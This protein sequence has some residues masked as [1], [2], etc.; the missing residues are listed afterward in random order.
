MAF[1]E[2]TKVQRD[3]P[4]LLDIPGTEL[5]GLTLKAPL[6]SYET[7]YTLPMSSLTI[8]NATGI[9][10]GVPSDVPVDMRALWELK[11]YPTLREKYNITEEMIDI[12]PISIIEIPGIGSSSAAKMV[13]KFEI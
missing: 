7:I 11:E 8:Q 5:I 4:S 1:Q 12:N 3:Y 6:S 2:M 10:I 13:Q 9:S